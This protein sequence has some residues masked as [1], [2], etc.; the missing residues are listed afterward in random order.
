MFT[1]QMVAIRTG[2][3]NAISAKNATITNPETASLFEEKT[4]QDARACFQKDWPRCP[5]QCHH[6]LNRSESVNLC[7]C[8]ISPALATGVRVRCCSQMRQSD[9]SELAAWRIYIRRRSLITLGFPAWG[10]RMR[11]E[12]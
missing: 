1:S 9:M 11:P 12:R 10:S 4:S 6:T 3:A 5:S 7:L 8:T 2:Y